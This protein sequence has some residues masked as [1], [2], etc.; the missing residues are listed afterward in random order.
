MPRSYVFLGFFFFYSIALLYFGKTGYNESDTID[1]FFI[2]GR[3]MGLFALVSTFVATWFSAASMQGLPGSI[4]VYG[5]TFVLYSI[6]PWF[7]GAGFLYLLTPKL[8]ASGA[9]SIPDYFNKRYQSKT[10]QV[11]TGIL[12]IFNFILY[13]V[14]QIRGFGIVISEFLEIPYTLAI[15]IVYIFILYTSFG[16]LF[17]LAKSDGF[18]F[19]VICIG[20]FLGTWIIL[21]R[22]DSIE[23]FINQAN[24]VEGYAIEGYFYYTPKASLLKPLAGGG[25]TLISLI[26]A[27]FAWGLGLATNPQYTVRII[28]AKDTETALEM[29]KRSVAILFVTY[30]GIIII[31]LG[32]RV[33]MPSIK[34]VDS[35]DSVLTV[36]INSLFSTPI[37]GIVMLA[38]MAAAIS[39]ANSQL[40]VAASSFIYDVF[41]IV[42]KKQRS[43]DVLLT[44][45][46]VVVLI[47][48]SLSL[49]LA[50]SPPESL[51]IYGSYIWGVFSVTLLIPLYGGVFWRD[52]TTNGAI[53]SMI[54]GMLT[55]IISYVGTYHSEAIFKI[56][57]SMPGVIVSGIVFYL[58]SSQERVKANE[59]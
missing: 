36:V 6:V 28:A 20:I 30:I 5:F 49:L 8:R 43:D 44:I 40:L 42:S 7:I 16:G 51:L 53:W 55:M 34:S 22:I 33:I 11:S 25:M 1:D 26:S 9:V 4:Y 45:S 57:P 17:S 35:I 23:T 31:G 56:H 52:A 15:V 13:I 14:I 18:N 59:N 32:M 10:L 50:I 12:I 3:K 29:I 46:R 37:S 58:V 24:A 27:F 47:V 2:G 48:G 39:T 54:S 19:I 38:I 21:F 41:G